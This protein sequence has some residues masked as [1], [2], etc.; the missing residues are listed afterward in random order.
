MDQIK[1]HIDQQVSGLAQELK[2]LKSTV[3]T[4]R[5]MSQIPQTPILTQPFIGDET[6]VVRPSDKQFQRIARRLS[7]LVTAK[8]EGG[9]PSPQ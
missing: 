2:E 6:P 1:Q 3:G 4:S 8:E 7:R 9:P 5:R